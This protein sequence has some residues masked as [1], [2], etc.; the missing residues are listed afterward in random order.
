M[1]RRAIIIT[2]KEQAEIMAQRD[3][4]WIEFFSKLRVNAERELAEFNAATKSGQRMC[5]Q[6][7]SGERDMTDDHRRILISRVEDH[8]AILR[9]E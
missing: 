5:V 3:Q 6:D 2:P 1:A 4:R 8:R 9:Q 7:D